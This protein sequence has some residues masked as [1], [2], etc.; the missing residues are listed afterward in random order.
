[1]KKTLGAGLGLLTAAV[2]AFGAPAAFATPD[3]GPVAPAPAVT[4]DGTGP[5]RDGTGPRA[6]GTCDGTRPMDGTG[7]RHRHGQTDNA[8]DQQ[9]PRADG[10]GEGQRRADGSAQ[11][12]RKADGTGNGLRDGTGPRAQ[13]TPAD[14]PNA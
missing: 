6:D 7:L 1:M 10:A 14:C 12:Q 5:A 3:P 11:G 8:D 2:I 9:Q 13:R 4:C